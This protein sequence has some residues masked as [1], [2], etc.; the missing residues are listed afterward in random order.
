GTS[1]LDA[2][3]IMQPNAAS[4]YD[5]LEL[6]P[7]SKSR[8]CADGVHLGAVLVSCPNKEQV[9]PHSTKRERG[10]K[11]RSVDAGWTAKKT[12]ALQRL[13]ERDSDLVFF[14]SYASG[15][16]LRPKCWPQGDSL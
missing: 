9:S 6:E 2:G 16:W 14:I 10:P 11:G 4:N 3:S 12:G 5:I 7:I 1:A 13:F 15:Q 8:A